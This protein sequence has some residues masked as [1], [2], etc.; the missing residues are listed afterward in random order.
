MV[1][2]KQ[3][4][5]Y[6]ITV[7]SP[8][9]SNPADFQTNLTFPIRLNKD[10]EYVL[11]LH[12]AVLTASWNTAPVGVAFTLDGNPV[13]IPEG[14]YNFDSLK[15][16]LLPYMTI[17]AIPTTGRCKITVASGTIVMA[18]LAPLLGFVEGNILGVGDHIGSFSVKI[19]P[20]N[21]ITVHCNLVD[22]N[23]TRSN[24]NTRPILR[25]ATLP[26][27]L[28]PFDYFDL[29]RDTD[30]Y[31][32]KCNNSEISSVEIKLTNDIGQSINLDSN[33]QTYFTISIKEI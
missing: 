8:N 11:S 22:F 5:I 30:D 20:V 23:S 14:H 28:A 24:L 33:I 32:V 4:E 29:C 9:G 10:K 7:H 6:S 1:Q 3:K 13:V 19:N 21:F 17:E 15:T 16:I 25:T 26:E 18:S 27:C 12:N 31:F 2:Q